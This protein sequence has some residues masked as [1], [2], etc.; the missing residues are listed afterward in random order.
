MT[1]GLFFSIGWSNVFTLAIKG[2]GKFTSQGSSLLVMAIA[3]G[4]ALPWVQS[5]VIESADVQTS[6]IIP[7]VGMLYL[8]FY[9]WKGH[10][11]MERK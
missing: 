4:A 6:F 7:V 11:I 3:G 1:F 8:I 9:G 10:E 5:H 2:L